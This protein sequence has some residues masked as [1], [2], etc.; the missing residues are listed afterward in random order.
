MAQIAAAL[1]NG[2]QLVEPT[3]VNRI[4]AGGG[5]PEE[6]LPA[7]PSVPLPLAN[8]VLNLI[9]QAL[10]DVAQSDNG[11]ATFIFEEFAV[12]V[13]GKTGTAETPQGRPHA[14]FIGF[15]PSQP[16]TKADGTVVNEPEIAIAVIMENAGEGSEVAAPL[17]RRIVALYYGL[18]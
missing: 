6:I 2:G 16:Y 7:R 15:A 4:G 17:F 9:N 10:R 18:D 14:W 1:A 8:E 12:P 13:A 3:I 11:T 5:A